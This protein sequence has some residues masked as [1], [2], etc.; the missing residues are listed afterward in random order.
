MTLFKGNFNNL[1]RN[2]LSL[3]QALGSVKPFPMPYFPYQMQTVSDRCE[4]HWTDGLAGVEE[5]VWN[6][7][8]LENSRQW[9]VRLWLQTH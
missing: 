7:H 9:A 5:I 2:K 1:L 8:R 4:K 6:D 3:I